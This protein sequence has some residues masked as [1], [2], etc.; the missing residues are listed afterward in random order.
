MCDQ[1]IIGR[2]SRMRCNVGKIDS[3]SIARRERHVGVSSS[4]G[5]AGLARQPLSVLW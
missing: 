1:S 3:K 2:H 5:N 4:D